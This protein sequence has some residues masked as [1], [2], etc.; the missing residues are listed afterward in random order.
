MKLARLGD[1]MGAE[2]LMPSVPAWNIEKILLPS[3]KEEIE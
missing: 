3:E 1:W 2:T